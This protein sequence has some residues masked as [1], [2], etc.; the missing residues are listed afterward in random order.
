MTAL[1][2]PAPPAAATEAPRPSV[3]ASVTRAAR[4]RE[5]LL[6]WVFA[7]LVTAT[8]H[9]S[10]M[11]IKQ[12]YLHRFTWTTR[13]ILWMSPLANL[14]LL[15]VPTALLVVLAWISPRY[16][17]RWLATFLPVFLAA[18]GMV[19][20][21][22]G[23]E[24][25]AIWVLALGVGVQAARMVGGN[26]D[27]WFPW[28][29]R[30]TLALG[31]VFVVLGGSTRLWRNTAEWRW[32]RTAAAAPADAP[33]VL[34]LLLDTVR[35]ENL[36]TYGYGRATSPVIDSVARGATVFNQAFST[37]GWTLPSHCSFFTGR[38]PENNTCGWDTSLGSGPRTVAEVFRDHGWRTAGFAANLFYATDETGLSRGFTR[39]EDFKVSFKQIICSSTLAQTAILRK[40]FWE[41]SPDDRFDALQNLQLKGDPKPE[42]DRR[43]AVDVADQYLNWLGTSGNRPFFA[44][45]N[46]FDA[47]EPYQPPE[48]WRTKFVKD[49]PKHLDRYDGGIAYM[50]QQVGR[51]LSELSKR[52]ILDKTVVV[53]AGDHGEQ[54]GEHNLTTHGNSLYIQLVHVPLIMR[55]P[56]RIAAGARVNRAITLRDLPR[57]LLDAAGIADT[58][59]I[60][61]TSLIPAIADSAY[62]T[63]AILAET[64]QT[65]KWTK[66]PTYKG[67]MSAIMD[68]RYHYMRSV[69]G[70]EWLYDYRADPSETKDLTKDSTHVAILADMRAKLKEHGKTAKPN[71]AND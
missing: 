44:Y 56:P 46:F 13:D 45:V 7:A 9:V 50:D 14:L 15:A 22:P 19:L 17:P 41:D 11:T 67:P 64:E 38:Y 62:A 20:I 69:T 26:G 43:Q 53:I 61:G 31:T 6:L 29:K 4:I 36:G 24:N 51:I 42:V 66:V 39:W 23:L 55:Y 37:A 3:V 21:V 25:Y 63:S 65:P 18:L 28:I 40:L 59:G 57:T 32:L 2:E 68:Q 70:A 1:H 34:I 30:I 35:A 47:H 27:R 71:A 49:K 33:N 54:F 5:I 8:W 16:V 10:K 48:E 58:K 60:F 12:Y 52:G